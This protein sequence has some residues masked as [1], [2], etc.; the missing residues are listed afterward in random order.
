MQYV[1]PARASGALHL[2]RPH[3]A[4]LKMRRMQHSKRRG[5][6]AAIEGQPGTLP[7]GHVGRV[8]LGDSS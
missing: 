7:Y 8:T 5:T 4:R 3:A 1:H 6:G 2:T